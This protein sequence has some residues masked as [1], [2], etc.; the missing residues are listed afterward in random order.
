MKAGVFALL[1]STGAA[2]AHSWYPFECC[3]DKDCFPMPISDVRVSPAGYT[4]HDGTLIEYHEARPSP[5]DRY[6]ICRRND[7]AGPIIRLHKKPACF[8]APIG[9]S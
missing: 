3:S 2:L 8:W 4:L 9:A 7:G 1:I 5:D 6:H